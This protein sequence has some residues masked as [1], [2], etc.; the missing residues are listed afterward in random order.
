MPDLEAD[1]G[2][3]KPEA[4]I[5]A[6]VDV[7]GYAD[8][9]RRAMRAHASQISEQSFFLALPRRGLRARVRHGVVHP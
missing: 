5:T 7:R 4:E 6:E 3:G 8:H 1:P 9:K 2:F